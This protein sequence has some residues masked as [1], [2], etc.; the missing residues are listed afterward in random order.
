MTSKK[1][2]TQRV[3]SPP[4]KMKPIILR[5]IT[6]LA[7]VVFARQILDATTEN[8]GKE[9]SQCRNRIT[10]KQLTRNDM[11]QY[12]VIL[13]VKLKRERLQGRFMTFP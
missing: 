12:K 2:Q 6:R 7:R 1:D 3:V 5:H 13:N 8:E 11:V 9:E 4:Q 10:W